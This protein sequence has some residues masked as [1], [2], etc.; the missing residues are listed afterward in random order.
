MND[1]YIKFARCPPFTPVEF[2][3]HGLV[4]WEF[5]GLMSVHWGVKYKQSFDRCC[6]F[7]I[8]PYIAG[9][10]SKAVRSCE[11]RWKYHEQFMNKC[12]RTVNLLCSWTVP[13]WLMKVFLNYCELFI[14][15][16]PIHSWTVHELR[17]HLKFIEN[18]EL[19]LNCYTILE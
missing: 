17:W 16:C 1:N 15:F 14:I 7:G 11:P 8:N 19:F 5:V 9:Y 2:N 6:G 3:T 13:E 18:H 12:W 4:H 10:A